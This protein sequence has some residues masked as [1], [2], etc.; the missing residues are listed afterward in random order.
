LESQDKIFSSFYQ[1]ENVKNTVPGSGIGLAFSKKLVELHGGKLTFSSNPV[2]PDKE[3]NTS[4]EIT[5]T[6]EENT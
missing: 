1:A 5:L 3:R 4:F 6:E 2:S